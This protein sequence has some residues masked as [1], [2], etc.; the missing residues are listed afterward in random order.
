MS[1]KCGK[2]VLG[3][4]LVA[5]HA[6]LRK[7]PVVFEL[8]NKTHDILERIS[9]R[10]VEKNDIVRN[11]PDDRRVFHDIGTKDARLVGRY[12]ELSYVFP[13]CGQSVAV[14][15]EEMGRS[16]TAGDALDS[17][18]PATGE[19]IKHISPVKVI[20]KPKAACSSAIL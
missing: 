6:S 10:G 7:P 1:E 2:I 20:R 19:S 14:A 16:S 17:Q 8:E 5:D 9:V 18:R 3:G 13:Q 12:P 4:V 15:L 11:S